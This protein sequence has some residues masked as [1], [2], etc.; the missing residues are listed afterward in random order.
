MP[1][2][3]VD[4]FLNEVCKHVK[5]RG[6]HK[7]ISDEL[8]NHIEDHIRD[9]IDSGMDEETAI[10]KAVE[11]MGDPAEI[12]NSLN[13]LHRPYLG[14]I[15]SITNTLVIAAVLIAAL[16]VIPGISM[17][18]KPFKYMP[19]NDYI[20]YTINVNQKA[21]IDER[22]IVIKKVIV[23]KSNGLHILYNDYCNPFSGIWPFMGFKISDDKSNTYE[24]IN[25]ESI[26]RFFGRKYMVY[27]YK[28]DKAA[29][30]LI[31]DYD[32][33]NRKMRFEIP[34]GGGSI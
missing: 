32:Y 11:T 6:A 23:D 22:T 17:A 27:I 21:R 30:K 18:F 20:K 33:Y 4:R 14:W 13:K 7:D 19:K 15:L 12:G 34:I 8:E 9:F 25:S 28:I 26:N 10:K 24:N 31:L 16:I 1:W 3:D 29:T 2:H 5:Y